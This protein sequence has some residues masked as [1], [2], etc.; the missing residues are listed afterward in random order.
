MS[1]YD[2]LKDRL[3]PF[4]QNMRFWNYKLLYRNKIPHIISI[5]Q[6]LNLIITSK[7]SI[8]RFGDGELNIMNGGSIG[9]CSSNKDLQ[10]RLIEISNHPIPNHLVCL[11]PML[12]N[13]SGLKESPRKYWKNLLAVEYP[14][15]LNFFHNKIYGNAFISRFYMDYH[16]NNLAKLTIMLWKKLWV[17]RDL[18]IVEGKNSRL[19]MGNNLFSNAKSVKRILCPPKDAFNKYNDIITEIKSLY[20]GQLVLIALGPTATVMAY[21]LCKLGVQSIDIGHIDI[22]YEWY[23]KKASSKINIPDKAVNEY[24]NGGLDVEG[25]GTTEYKGQIVKIIG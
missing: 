23:L 25:E 12:D 22:E 17:N 1:L 10:N 24:K 15:W 8:S 7:L 18:L 5:E 4:Y 19:G 6:T 20:D 2:K 13:L 3:R 21:D 11:P 14:L 16:N 9:F